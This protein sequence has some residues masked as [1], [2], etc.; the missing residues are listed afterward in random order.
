MIWPWTSSGTNGIG[1]HGITFAIVDSSSGA[2]AAAAMKPAMVS[3]VAGRMS[4]PPT[5]VGTSWSAYLKRVTT[6]KLP[7]PP[8]I[9]QNRSG[10]GVGVHLEGFAVG[11]DD[12]GRQERVD[13]EPELAHEVADPAAHR[14][15]ADPDR[16]G[17]AEA[18]GQAVFGRRR[19]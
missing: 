9:A 19:S 3:V 10:S 18:D 11:R 8:R 4:M 17:V 13:R 14:D 1:G 12:L 5:V 7:P 16:S 6:P 15:P 2:S